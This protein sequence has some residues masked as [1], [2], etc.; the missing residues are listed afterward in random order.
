MKN[1]LLLSFGLLLCS[2]MTFGQMPTSPCSPSGGKKA[3]ILSVEAKYRAPGGAA[4]VFIIPAGT[5]SINVYVS[6]ETGITTGSDNPQGDEDFIN[7]SAVI[8]ISGGTSSGYVN[9]AK[10]TNTDG[11]GTN[12]YGWQKVAL[13]SFIPAGNKV[14]DATPTDLNNVKF[15]IS[16]STLTITETVTTTHS[17]YYVEYCSPYNNSLTP[18]DPQVKALLHGT[19]TA[20]TDLVIAIPTGTNI[21]S[22][23]GKGT[24]TSNTDL[25]TNSGTEEGY[26]NM[27][28]TIDLDAALTDGVITLANGGSVDRRSTYVIN[29]LSSA[30]TMSFLSSA[31]ITGDYSTKLGTTGAVGVCNP[32]IYISGTNLVIKR[33]ANYARDFD[34]AYVVEFYKR[35]GQGMSAE[36]FNT[37]FAFIAKGTSSSAGVAKTFSIPL[38]TTSMYLNETGNAVNTDRESNENSLAAYAYID[39]STSTA[40][41]YFYQQVG[42]DGATRRDDNFAFKSVPL[43]GTSARNHANTVGYK[44]G[45]GYDISFSLSADKTTLTVTNKTGLANPDYQILESMDYYGA[46]PDI[47]FNAADISFT[48]GSSCN[49]VRASVE[50]CNPGAGNASAGM[51]ISIYHGDPTTDPAAILLYTGTFNQTI[52]QGECKT[53]TYDMDL[54]AFDNLDFDV[55]LIINDNGSFV[56]GGV[57]H[58]VGTPFTL[59]SLASQNT[60]Y[61]EC[62]F[63]NNLITKAMDVNNCP[64]A[65]LDADNSSG[66]TGNYNYLNYFNAGSS[67][68]KITDTDLSIVDYDGD[69]METAVITL[70]NVL[71]AGSEG[72]YI[73]GTLPAGITATGSGTSTITLTGSASQAN[74]IAALKL[75]EY[76]NSNSAPNTTNR[77]ITTTLNDGTETGPA[78]TTT[79]IITTDPRI[80]VTGNGT[81]IND[82]S[83]TVTTVDGTDFGTVTAGTV[84]N[85]FVINNVGTGVIN[86]TGTPN[87]AI[88]GDAG[89]TVSAQPTGS[90]I[91]AGGSTS[92]TVTFNAASHTVGAYVAVVRILNNDADTGRA[93]YSYTVMATVNNLPVV[94]NSTVTGIED[95]TLAFTATNFT[96]QYSDADG[97]ALNKIRIVT[98]PLNGSF[99]LNGVV[100]TAGQEILASQLGNITF[101]PTANWNGTTSFDWRASDGTSYSAAAAKMTIVITAVNDAPVITVPTSIAVTEDIPASLKDISFADVDAG[102]GSVTVT[103]SVPDGS[104]SAVSGSGVVVSGTGSALVLTGTITDIN[105]FLT[106]NKVTYSSSQNPPATVTLTV[107]VN[108]N[109]NTGAGGAKQDTKTVTLGI[110]AVNDAPV[111][112]DDVL[113][114]L[115]DNVGT[116]N[117]LTNDTD[118][119]GNALTASVQTGPVHGTIVLNTNGSYTYTPAANYNGVD[120]VKYSVCDNGTPNMCSVGTLRITIT[121]VNDAPVAVDDVLTILEDNVGTGNVLT[122]DTDVE[123][124]ALTASVQTGPVHGTIVLNTN[125]SYTYTPAA[126]YNGVDSVK[127]NVCDN[128]TPGMCSVGTLRITV[129]PVNDAPTGVDQNITTPEDVA[130]SGSVVG[131]DVDGDALTYS[132]ATDPSHGTAIVNA[133]GT[134]TYTPATNYNGPDSFTIEINDGNGGTATVT[135]N[136][137]VTAVNDAPTGADQT[138]TTPE[139]TQYNGSVVGNDV[140]GD[141]LTYSKATDPAHG[142]ATVNA[143]GTYTYTPAANYN[144]PD[145]FTIGINDG[146][147]GTAT[148]TINITVTAVNDAPT[149]TD[150]NITTPEDTP[151]NGSVVGSDVDGDALTYSKATD[152][153]HGTA[154]VNADGTYT[155][156]PAANYNGPDSFTIGINDGN[157]GTATVTINI[158]VTA[159]NDDP[160]GADQNI[161]TP[162]DTPYNGSVVGSDVDGDALAYSKATDPGHGTATVN[163]DGTYT[164]TP[165]ANYNGADSFTIEINDGNGGTTTVTINITVT[166]V[167]DAPTGADQNIATPEDVAYNGSVVGSD[168]DGDALT[169]SKGTD[170]AH[171]TATVNADGTYTY[172]PAANFNGADSFTIEINDGNGGT[173]T[174]TINITVTAV[175]DAPTGADQN[176]TTPEDTPYNGSV[177]GSDVDGDAL[178]YS[179]ATDPAHGTATVNADGTYTYTP[180]ANYNGPDSFTIEINDGNGG[181]ITLTINITVT[182]VNDAPTGADQNITTPEDTP[183][184]GSV[185]G[186]DVDGDALTYSKA[187][188]PAHGT[189]T[190]NADG[191]YTYTP[192]SNYNGPDSFTIEINDG[193]GGSATVTI[194]ITVTAVNDAPTGADQTITTPE[195]TQYNGSIVGNDVDGDALTYS[196]ATDPAHGTATVNADGT[197]TYTPAA[198]YNGPD[199]FTIEINDGNG[200]TAT[201]TIN[202]TVTAVNDAPTGTDQNITT[203]EDTPYNGSVVG[204]D[205]DGDALTYSKAT[206]PSHGTAT[207]NA[208]GTYTYTPAADYNGADSFTIEINDGNGGTATV[209][210]NITVTAVNDAPTGADQNITTPEDI[211]YNG[212]AVGNDVDGDA[213]TYSK[214]TDPGHG[215]ATVNADGT[216]TYTPAANYNGPDSFTIEINDGNGST[217]TVTINITV[218]AVNDAPTGT[219]QNITTP[220]DT[221]YNGSVVGS[222]VDGDALT[223]SKATD[224][225]HGTATVNADGTYT[226]TPAADYNGADS[227]TIEINDGNG[228]TATVTIN[229]TVTA[230]NDAP[231]GADQNITTPEDIPYNGSA[232]GNDVDG[233]A[234]TY[235]KATDPGHG[236]ATVNAD[237]TYTYTPAANYNGPD[238]FTIEINDGNGGT[239][240]VSINITVTVVNDDPTGA[241]QNIT[242]PEDVVYN[243]SVVGSDVD[244]DALTYSKATDP[245]HGTATVNADGTYTYTPASNYYGADSFT[246]EINDGNGGTATVAIN[247]T[248]T[249]VNDDPTGSDQTITTPEDTQYNGS[250][251]GNDVDGDALT[252]NKTT[253]PAHGTATVNTDGTYTYT[254]A[255]N[256]N[257]PDSFT[258]EI[259]DGNGG[260]ATVTINI[261][262]TAVNDDPTGL[263]QNITTPEDVA[264]N[265]S[266]V[267]NDVDGDALIYNKATDPGHGTATVNADGTYTYTPAASYNGPDS[268]TIEINDGNGGTTTITIDITVT[269]VN[270]APTGA[271]QNITTPEDVAYN[272]SV[273]GNDVD[274]DVLTYNKATDPAHGTATVNS[275]GT[276]TYTPTANYNGA[277]SFT[278]EINDGNGGTATVTIN[279]TVTSVNDAPTGTDQNV[280]TP[281]DT[282]YNGSVIGSDVD[283]DALTYSKATDPS[284]GTA[285]VNADGTYTYTPASNYNGPD[286]FT[287]EINDGNGGTTTVTINITVTAVND[288]PTGVDQNI[289]TPEDV[290]Y[291]GSVVGSDV[292]GDALAYSKASDPAHG[293]ATVNADGTYTYTPAANYNGP[294]SFTIEINDGNGGTTTVTI[295]ITVT[296]VNDA[297]TGADQNIT[298]PEDVAY[299]G[300]VVGS[301]VDGDALTYSKDTDPTHGTAAINADGTYT[302]TPAADYN[303]PDSFTIEINDGNG[304]TTTVTINI[305]VTAVND[306]PTGADQNITTPEDIQYNGSVV[307]NDVDGDAL[308]YSKATDPTHG[309]ATVNADGTYTYTPASNYNGPDSF[310]IEINDGNGG[311]T[312]VTINITVTA[313]NDAPTGA[314]Q[315]ITTPEDVAYN[316]TVVGSDVD[317]DALTYS[318]DSDPAHGTATVNAD[319]TYNYTPATNYNGPD[320]FTIEINDG[321]GGTAT[322]TI[323]ITVTAVNDDPTGSDQTITTPE[324]TQ[325]NGSVVGND[326]DGDVL[327]YNKATDPAHGTATVN[328]DG[329]YTYTPASNYNGPDSFTIEINDGNGGAATVTINITVTAVNDDPTGVDQDVTTPED[330]AY[331]GNVVG[332]DVDGDVLTYSKSIDPTHGTAIVNADGTYTYTPAS[333]YNGP[334]SFTIEINDGNGGTATVTINITVTAVNDDPTGSDQ[335][336]T[337]PED[338][339]Y[340]GSVVGNDADGDVLTYNK[341]TDPAHGTATVNADGTY[342]YTPTADYNGPDSFTIEIN[343][344]N[345]GTTTVTINITVT[346]VNDA[347][348]GADQNITTPEDVAYNGSVVGSDVD[349]DAL[350]YSKATDPA[351]GTA[352]VNADGTY[353]YTPAAN[354]NGPDSFTIEIN[355]GNGGTATVT[356]NITVTAVNDDPTGSDQNI[357][358]PEDVAYNGSVVGNDVDGGVLTYSK[359]T[360]P[361]HGTATVN[362]DGTYTYTP[363]ADYNGPDSFTI[364]INDGNGGTTTV[365]INITVTAVNDAPTGADQNITTPEDVAY[366]GSVV[367]ND[368]DG[369]VLTYSKDSDPAHGTATV[370]ADGTYTYTPAAD[371]NGPDSFTIEINDG[372]GGIA[373][374]TIN[375]TVTAVNDAPTGSDQTITTPEDTQYNGSVVGNDVDGDALTY[376]KDSD[377]S[378]GTATVDADGTYTYTPTADY[379]GPDSFTIEINDGNGGTTTV[380]ITITVTAVN[381]APTGADQNI[382]TPEDVAFNGSVVGNDVDGDVLTYSK[383][384]DPAH[385]TA[386]VNADGTYTYTPATDYNGPDSFTIEINDGNG[387]TAT[388]TI[389]ITVTA[390]NDAPTGADQTITTP[391][392]TQYNGSVVGNDVDGDA[393]TYSK[394]SDPAHGTATVNADGTYTYTPAADYNGPDSFTIEINDGNGGTTTVTINITVT[395]VNDAPTGADQNITT[396]EDVAYNGSVVGNDV[397]GDALTYSKAT[398]P[399]HGTATVNADGTYTYT[400]AANYNGPDSFTIEINDGNGGTATVTINI[401]VTAVN[402]APTGTDQNI[403]TPEDMPYNGSVTGSDAD[404][405]ALTYNKATDP[406]HGTATVNADGTYTYTPTADYN[407][408]DSFTIEINDGNGGIATV[409]INI[410][411]TAVNDAPTGADQTITTPEDT[412]YNGSVVGSDVDG[413][414]LTYSKATDPAHGTA[415]V[416]AAGTYTYTPAA[417]YNGPDSFTI[418]INDGNGGTA[419]V[420]INI[421]VT[422]VN[423]APTGTDQNITTP[424]DTPYNGSVT[425]SDADGDALTYNKA[426]DPAHGTATVNADGTYTYTPTADYNGPD[427]F[428]IEINDGNGGIAT[429]TINIT[430]TAVNDAPTGADQTITTP[431][432]TQYNGSVVGSDVDGDALTYS[433]ATDPAHGTATVNAAGTYTYIPAANYNGPDSFTIEINDGNGGTATVTINITVTAVNDAPTGT[434]QNITTPED[435]PYNG[436][437]TGSDADGDALTYSKATDPAHGIATVN[438][439]GTYTY[440]P[441]ANYN[442]ADSFAIEINDGNGGTAIVTINITVTP[443]NDAPTA[444]NQIVTTPED[445]PYNGSVIGTDP[446]GDALTFS[447]GSNPTNGTATVNADGTFTYTPNANYNGTDAFTIVISDGHSGTTTITVNVTVTP[448]NDAPTG[449][450]LNIT[451]PKNTAYTG[452]VTGADID[453]DVLTYTKATDPSYGTVVVNMNGS[454]TYTPTTGYVGNDSFTVTI[455]DGQYSIT[456]TVYITVTQVITHP[457]IT[458]VK[459]AVLNGNVITYTFTTTNTGDVP[460]INV[461]LADPMVNLNTT[462]SATLQSG[463]VVTQTAT[464]TL[465]QTDRENESVTNT[466]TVSGATTDH[467]T[468]SD[469]SGT[470]AGNDTPTTITV[471]GAPK[472]KDDEYDTRMNTKI[473]F[474]FIDNDDLGTSTLGTY[475]IISEVQHGT[476][477]RDV[478]GYTEYTPD[479]GYVGDDTF[480]YT[481]TDADGYISNVATVI[482]HIGAVYIAVPTLFTPNGD[483]K[484]DVFEIVGL[485][486]YTENELIIVNRWG[487]E[488]YRQHNYSNTWT[489]D[490]LSEGTYYYL[491]RVKKQG[492]ADWEVF[493]GFTTILRKFKK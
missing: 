405:D 165:A 270:D 354:Y 260:T 346:A 5:S 86:L 443:V 154:T 13:G 420:T 410:T 197:Y 287:I 230:V 171:G 401:T 81:L 444:F 374:V 14:G 75:I 60:G 475:T 184:N 359:A 192:A 382:T 58:A 464:Y 139:D 129:T 143:D 74:Y 261:T 455:S 380:T 301:D 84:T 204:S 35:V 116:G 249:A 46:R 29:N 77:I 231:T 39:L 375:I 446:D 425:G 417:N 164:Y 347:P 17:S 394:D 236:T 397:D 254:P 239:A 376:S 153:A 451:T 281:E 90:S 41:G 162:E 387:G 183:Y 34:D 157:G 127:Y 234:L 238:S 50:V 185:V 82:N 163:A 232:V 363:T 117:V 378:H 323:N 316:G 107:N 159:V 89:F 265:G 435:T 296:A 106:A 30:S 114:I 64:K 177:V 411:V 56:S 302:Y 472:A 87:V 470:T 350:T 8:D 452:N 279:I 207:V 73:N 278:I 245:G 461:I 304:G 201:V 493:K 152:P 53:F 283:G 352:T 414:A 1:T 15:A 68:A 408:P 27:R 199:S 295:N 79:I 416:N 72:L 213:L 71:D 273:V 118:V 341:A 324:D 439:N 379:N 384:S 266:V 226:Y 158:T 492:G 297:P 331:N 160:T 251:V 250:V 393:L 396:P 181:T 105:A 471:P 45:Y 413:D 229:I 372:N 463:A 392:D 70:T 423:D 290:A 440:T 168:L 26:S 142:T 124:D 427:S 436:S 241:D 275:D 280:T 37:D 55:T 409:T 291:N 151:Y 83:G 285:T 104:V 18:L 480:T 479:Q 175:N 91:T 121:A 305:T 335:T 395:A 320:S 95:N 491:L 63:D 431:E 145:S 422:A 182:A 196:K 248:V 78:S 136:I 202:I 348:T 54:S 478:N 412:Q 317:G 120:S 274:G 133:D 203:P 381:D 467:V 312:T 268:F 28:F 459:T 122:N 94:T 25:N 262:V 271:D 190:V 481:I 222:D 358:T 59:S 128:G 242:T 269:A 402:D 38:G 195:D 276:Y 141:A 140:D 36:F 386:T 69:N 212:S 430:V 345:G 307:G 198:N 132:K 115:E 130:Y 237:G 99:R 267:G 403:T 243:G 51:P 314:D 336:I 429:V 319:G 458:L 369:D 2:L 349:G 252:Y 9:V 219:D 357:T 318:K 334:D 187:T 259:N 366:N 284:H 385:G 326:A 468:V 415:T 155:Y 482:I 123:G 12:V 487:N 217:A 306:A 330:V 216:Y 293:T 208:D 218:T 351:H 255:S 433:K 42:L 367:G 240:T 438:T 126:N 188:D 256:Y 337:T 43:D 111:A 286:S 432:D 169:Y 11:S 263:D 457:G 47:A 191:T 418:E 24:N 477:S 309:T 167:N 228:G 332:N 102:T 428:T 325:Y 298:T 441:A 16:G 224:P 328:A 19:G 215:T 466:A 189:A 137:T 377:P 299:N 180:A 96:S 462:I 148:V 450:D 421:T 32:Q 445:T 172:T 31:A 383:D 484:N 144:G 103:F 67:G 368:V 179:K 485:E 406:A 108:D 176:I 343:D 322:V 3:D 61:K 313:V 110:T 147:G 315:N 194:N 227:F 62:Y 288:A 289:T 448:V 21:I 131:S 434:D 419:T 399:A 371:Y 178:A 246:I 97:T 174:V 490:G 272:G 65:N 173:A 370:N 125:G 310:T 211:P 66:A 454:F 257:G 10:N 404:G 247:I 340:N 453:G 6:S 76:R 22:I 92:F 488:V 339:Q 134:Y 112:V 149:G 303:G 7:I 355:D 258:I 4:P 88:S 391:E 282:P 80:N 193:N 57:G 161:T 473:S 373:T 465:T 356:I 424:E 277:D 469:I 205:V 113:T 150:Q 214:A 474:N 221:P 400:P 223:Y 344:G 109:G 48:K 483:G 20:N 389:N 235:S 85:T 294:D 49:I 206:D 44:G 119:E 308:T 23:Q 333:N 437:V 166:A 135:I 40:T 321:N 146:N 360:D 170:P 156:T 362:A 407:G 210:I 460:L 361:S 311:T 449:T 486:K 388:V 209:T 364:E 244:G 138:I 398:D 292:D 447:K 365:T 253:D 101:I 186:N 329:T 264:Y 476:I 342:T 456:I 93:D 489:G 233:D 442:G 327:T 300:T 220:E 98:L 338:T 200:S 353:T 225:S 52:L 426:T 390:V 33:D 100:I